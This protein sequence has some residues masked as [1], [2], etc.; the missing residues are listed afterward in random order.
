MTLVIYDMENIK[1]A[2]GTTGETLRTNFKFDFKK[3][4]ATI[5]D[6]FPDTMFSH[7]IFMAIKTESE[8]KFANALK[9][10]GHYVTTKRT[11]EKTAYYEGAKYKFKDNDMD[12]HI[13]SFMERFSDNYQNVLLVSGDGDLEQVLTHIKNKG[14]YVFVLGWKDNMSGKLKKFPHLHIDD[15]KEKIQMKEEI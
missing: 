9:Y 4:K 2:S 13:V 15:W 12:A 8:E 3:L 7:S 10:M 11:R 6:K 5:E 14:K 1:K